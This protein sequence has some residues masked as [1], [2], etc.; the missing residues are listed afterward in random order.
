MEIGD[1]VDVG[2]QPQRGP[3]GSIGSTLKSKIDETFGG[4]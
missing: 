1:I 3:R 4:S 2:Q